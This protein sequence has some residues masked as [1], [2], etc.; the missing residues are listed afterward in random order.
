MWTCRC[1]RLYGPFPAE[2]IYNDKSESCQRCRRLA[3]LL[4]KQTVTFRSIRQL[5]QKEDT[6]LVEDELLYQTSIVTSTTFY[7]FNDI[8]DHFIYFSSVGIKPRLKIISIT[9]LIISL[10]IA[11]LIIFNYRS[12][13]IQ[14]FFGSVLAALLGGFYFLT[15]FSEEWMLDYMEN[16][17][18]IDRSAD[19]EDVDA[20]YELY[21]HKKREGRDIPIEEW[22]AWVWSEFYEF[23]FENHI[24][25]DRDHI[26]F[27]EWYEKNIR[28]SFLIE[29]NNFDTR[30]RDHERELEQ[31]IPFIASDEDRI[32]VIY[33]ICDE[34]VLANLAVKSNIVSVRHHALSRL[35]DPFLLSLVART[36]KNDE[37]IREAILKI[38]DQATLES[39]AKSATDLQVKK[40]S[41]SFV[42][43]QEILC[44]IVRKSISLHGGDKK[45]ETFLNE[46][47]AHTLRTIT[48]EQIL[49]DLA[50]EVPNHFIQEGCFDR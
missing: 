32:A 28:E 44:Q 15:L 10:S 34:S 26:E 27:R 20:D 30:L 25:E 50:E 31:K 49:K 6:D 36:S 16:K 11:L 17:A 18:I 42:N 48:D 19:E 5:G 22:N 40:L 2:Q 1:L 47:I 3:K 4:L 37:I 43:N 14:W 45:A 8:K 21:L 12:H 35:S 39:L 38:K 23:S 7:D 46:V 41:I 13:E 29:C 9:L 24:I 33:E